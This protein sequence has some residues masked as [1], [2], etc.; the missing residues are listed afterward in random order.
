MTTFDELVN[1]TDI[2][3]RRWLDS[4]K[5]DVLADNNRVVLY[6]RDSLAERN[7]TY[8]IARWLPGY[9]LIGDDSGGRGFFLRCDRGSGPVFMSGL[10]ALDEDELDTVA[11][12]FEA[13]L[14]SGFALPP[15]PEPELPHTADIYIDRVPADSVQTLAR[16][17]K[18]LG[19]TWPVSELR[20]RLA[21]QPFLAVAAGHPYALRRRLDQAPDLRPYLFHAANGALEPVWRHEPPG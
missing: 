18:L 7:A 11:P 2:A 1:Q 16:L 21:A 14:H 8:D 5:D 15:D 13:W 20:A 6:W 12:A 9:L 17:K 4:I 10:G 19:T 3:Y